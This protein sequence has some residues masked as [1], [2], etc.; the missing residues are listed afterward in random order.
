VDSF[1]SRFQ[2][3]SNRPATIWI[4]L[5]ENSGTSATSAFQ[6]EAKSFRS[7]SVQWVSPIIFTGTVCDSIGRISRTRRS[8]SPSSSM[9]E[10]AG[11]CTAARPDRSLTSSLA[12]DSPRWASASSSVTGRLRLRCAMVSSRVS[13]PVPGWV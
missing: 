3:G 4:V 10:V 6:A 5:S 13:A 12:P 9:T 2:I 8:I 7:A 1:G 11:I